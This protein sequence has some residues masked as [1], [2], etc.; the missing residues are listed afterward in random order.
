MSLNT[1]YKLLPLPFGDWAFWLPFPGMSLLLLTLAVLI[2]SVVAILLHKRHASALFRNLVLLCIPLW[3][4]FLFFFYAREW[5]FWTLG[6]FY[7]LLLITIIIAFLDRK[8][9]PYMLA[10]LLAALLQHQG[11]VLMVLALART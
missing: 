9:F 3:G 8:A 5:L 7:A 1:A 2:L 4:G 6:W 11:S 10:V